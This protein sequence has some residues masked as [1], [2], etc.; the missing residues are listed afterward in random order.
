MKY[1]KKTTGQ[2]LTKKNEKASSKTLTKRNKKAT[3]STPTKRNEKTTDKKS[4]RGM[5]KNNKKLKTKNKQS[6]S[7]SDTNKEPSLKLTKDI[8]FKHFFKNNK[9]FCA[10]L[11]KQFIPPL[12]DRK[13]K[14]LNFLDSVTADHPEDKQSLLDIL[15]Q[16]DEKELINIEMQYFRQA[17]FTERILFYWAKLFL[18]QS[19]PGQKYG[20]LH[21]TYSLVFTNY[22]LF[23]EL[24][25]YCSCFSIQCEENPHVVFSHHFKLVLVELDKF[26]KRENIAHLDNKELWCYLLNQ[27]SELTKQEKKV[28]KK[29]SEFM[30]EVVEKLNKQEMKQRLQLLED[31]REKA[32]YDREAQMD[33][34]KKEARRTGRREGRKEGRKEGLEK[35][36]KKVALNL[37]KKNIDISIISETTGLSKSEIEKLKNTVKK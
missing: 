22:T 19:K 16:V 23:K 15:V 9:K 12:K 27:W 13:I 31:F 30:K 4:K 34:A 3:G 37:L 1:N 14:I 24:K 28:L 8:A 20:S 10:D 5:E 21:P 18:N 11:I 32:R 29:R 26:K 33:Y 36:M 6:I 17:H 2:T 7:A 25:E 35:G